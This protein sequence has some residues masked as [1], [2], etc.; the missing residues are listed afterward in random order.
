MKNKNIKNQPVM[1]EVKQKGRP[2]NPNSPRQLRLQE[3]E[4]KKQSGIE[5]KKGRPVNPNSSR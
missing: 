2:V 3:Q 5:M 4:L 1:I